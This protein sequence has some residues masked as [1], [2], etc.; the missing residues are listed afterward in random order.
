MALRAWKILQDGISSTAT[1]LLNAKTVGSAFANASAIMLEIVGASSPNWTVDIQGKLHDAGTYDN[2]DYR[3]IRQGA[4]GSARSI[5]QLSVSDTTRRYYIVENPPP[6]MQVVS[7]RTAGNLTVRV[8]SMADAIPPIERVYVEGPVAHDGVAA[9]NPVLM[10]GRAQTG[11]PS[12]VAD[13][14]AVLAF[15]DEFGSLRVHLSSPGD[16]ADYPGIATNSD[17]R[18]LPPAAAHVGVTQYA[19]APDGQADRLRTAYNSPLGVLAASPAVPGASEVKSTV[20]AIGASSATR[21]TFLT[22]TSG[23]RIRVM[24]F[25]ASA[26]GLTTDP[27]GV[28]VYFGTGAAVTTNPASIAGI[29]DT[30]TDGTDDDKFPDGGGPVG[31]ANEVLSWRTETETETGLLGV[32]VYREE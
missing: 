14:D 4:G 19:L 18:N 9:G 25:R 3:E 27:D 20:I 2:W 1:A 13:L 31:V 8:A 24:S 30:G 10:G 11:L 12:A 5:A 32:L 15:F 28:Q 29:Y 23:K 21:A 22:P 16:S 17:G 26:Q 6:F 7:T